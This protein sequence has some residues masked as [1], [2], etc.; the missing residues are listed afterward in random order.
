MRDLLTRIGHALY[1][2][3][4]IAPLARDLGLPMMTLRHWAIGSRNPADPDGVRDQLV[5]L[6][7]KRAAELGALA[8]EASDAA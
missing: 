1:G 4:W 7:E 2:E 8:A 5:S 3:R 6:T